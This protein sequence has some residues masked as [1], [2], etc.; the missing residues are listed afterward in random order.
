MASLISK[1]TFPSRSFHCSPVRSR[2]PHA[3]NMTKSSAV[4]NGGISVSGRII[5]FMSSTDRGVMADLIWRK[6]VSAFSSLQLCKT[7]PK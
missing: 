5:S 7:Q 1:P 4:A 3:P 2:L 6:M